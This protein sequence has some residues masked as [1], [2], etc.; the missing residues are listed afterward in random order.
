MPQRTP[1][2][3]ARQQALFTQGVACFNAGGYFAAHEAWEHI[4]LALPDG[5]PRQALQVLIQMA[6]ALELRRRGK[7][8]GALRM[9]DRYT[10]RLAALPPL[11]LG[12]DLAALAAEMDRALAPIDP[13]PENSSPPRD[14]SRAPNI[15]PL[16]NPFRSLVE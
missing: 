8:A 2:P 10:A 5:Q 3:P 15:V 16:Y 7:P 4:W 12:I 11:A 9:R 13:S 6:V 14:I 1:L